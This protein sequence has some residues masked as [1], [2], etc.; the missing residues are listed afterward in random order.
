[1]MPEGT[2]PEAQKLTSTQDVFLNLLDAEALGEQKWRNWT[3][4]QSRGNRISLW[5]WLG[6]KVAIRS[7]LIQLVT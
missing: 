2:Q 1:M 7:Y 4:I 3:E 5:E 6:M